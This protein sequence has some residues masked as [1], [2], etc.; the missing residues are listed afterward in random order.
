MKAVQL[1]PGEQGSTSL[2]GDLNITCNMVLFSSSHS[3]YCWACHHILWTISL[4][5]WGQMS[6]L[7]PLPNPCASPA[8][9]LM[10]WCEKQKRSWLSISLA[11][12]WHPCIINTVFIRNPQ[13]SLILEPLKKMNSIQHTWKKRR[14]RGGQAGQRL[15]TIWFDFS[16]SYSDLVGKRYNFPKSQ[17]F[18][19]IFSPLCSWEGGQ[20][21]SIWLGSIQH[22]FIMVF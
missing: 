11:Q 14:G 13:H 20:F 5:N 3:F 15:F 2:N 4:V 19:H 6:H 9:L 7:F 10:G 16:L 8:S 1:S 21:S 22:T 12:Q 17:A 18:C